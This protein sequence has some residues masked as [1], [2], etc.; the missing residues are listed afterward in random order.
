MH[1]SS[2][3]G[4]DFG[5]TWRGEAIRHAD[6]FSSVR[7][8]DRVGVVIPRRF[9]GLGASTLIMSYVTAFYDRYRERGSEFFA[10]PDFFT[11]QREA[12]CADYCMFDIWPYH[13][14]IHVPPDAQQTAEAITGRGVTVLLVPDNDVGEIAIA[15]VEL[16]SARRNV[17]RC[18]AYSDTGTTASSDL[19]IECRSHLLRDFALSVLD[20]LP[21]D[22]AGQEQRGR[23]E[24]Q[25]ATDSLRQTF[26]Q[27]DL[28]D[29]LRRI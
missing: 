15:P 7:D 11:F 14:N 5:I 3:R 16:E 17:Q 2:I 20:S 29:A 6:L 22:D 19:V 24:E 18:F 9:E 23:W 1:S 27:L 21:A 8:T 13:K 28:S 10:Y 12:P 4:T 25:M 26:R